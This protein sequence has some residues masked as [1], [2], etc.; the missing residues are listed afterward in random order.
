MSESP[1]ERADSAAEQESG[2]LQPPE[3]PKALHTWSLFRTLGRLVTAGSMP[4]GALPEC[5]GSELALLDLPAELARHG[6]QSAQL[7]H[8]YLASRESGYLA[9]LRTAFTESGVGIECLLIDDGDL[10]HPSQAEDH[11]D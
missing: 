5:V 9:E 7:C 6:Y 3:G 2:S 8:F 10:T 1:N 4:S 11:Q